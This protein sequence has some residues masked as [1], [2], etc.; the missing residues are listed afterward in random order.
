[1]DAG[2]NGTGLIW[3]ISQYL[4]WVTEDNDEI[5]QWEKSTSRVKI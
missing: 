4:L 1:M 2:G 5:R 3:D